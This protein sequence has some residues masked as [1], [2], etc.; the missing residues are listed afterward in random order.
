MVEHF[1]F[2]N[3]ER[4]F[5]FAS[6]RENQKKTL[7]EI[8]KAIRD[9]KKFIILSMP[10]GG[11]KSGIS[12]SVA[13]AAENAFILTVNKILQDQYHKDFS[14]K[15][16]DLRGRSNYKCLKY[17]GF[18]CGNSPCRATGLAKKECAKLKMC[19]YHDAVE[20]AVK[21][22]ITS[23]NFAAG[24]AFINYTNHFPDGRE[25][26][27]I[28][29]CH[30]IEEVLTQYLEFTVS[31]KDLYEYALLMGKDKIPSFETSQEYLP[32][33]KN[34]SDEVQKRLSSDINGQIVDEPEDVADGLEG[35]G[36]KLKLA[37]V[38]IEKDARNMI[39]DKHYNDEYDKKN[40]IIGKLVFRPIYVGQFAQE[41][42]FSAAEV[43][44][45][46]SATIVSADQFMR[47]V[48][49]NPEEAHYIDV[50][51]TFPVENRPLVKQYVGN[52]NNSNMDKMLPLIEKEIEQILKSHKNEKGMIHTHTYTNAK[53]LYGRLSQKFPNRLIFPESSK[54]QK[55]ALEQHYSS[56]EPTVLIS[57]SMTEGVDLKDDY[58]RFQ[59]I[60][61]V[62]Y[63]YLGDS[64]VKARMG[65]NPDWYSWR[66]MLTIMQAYGRSTRSETDH[67][68]TY[69]LD[70]NFESVLNRYKKHLPKYFLDAIM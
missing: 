34:L 2:E 55:A 10:T 41:S 54:N 8:E 30:L 24:V 18:N 64:V 69:I 57:P 29:E 27:V 12:L 16:S 5:P 17:S 58:C 31:D 49:I 23:F 59:V 13:S 1:N 53:F 3:F 68:V 35:L 36:R 51:S 50:D 47:S 15:L 60:M 48:G 4:L 19:E 33:L 44:I 56:K 37:I 45:M 63:P 40:G 14:N 65:I 32:W 66:T 28:D 46:M 43:V 62:P 61:K 7:K 21:A 42:L 67:S 20:E 39:V 9:G 25:L 52:L 38:E 70:G 26:M 6:L 11:G 22:K